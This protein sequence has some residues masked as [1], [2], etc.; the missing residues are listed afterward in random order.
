VAQRTDDA[1]TRRPV[2]GIEGTE[3]LAEVE[4]PVDG[5]TCGSCAARVEKV[6]SRQPGVERAL[7]NLAGERARV[8]M[9]PATVGVDDLVEAVGG[10]GYGLAPPPGWSASCAAWASRWR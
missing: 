1:R 3:G 4:L 5:M 8:V 6:L 10:A 7:V 2:E 9:D